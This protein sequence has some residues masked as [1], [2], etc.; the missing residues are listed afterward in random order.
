MKQAVFK[1]GLAAAAVAFAATSSFAQTKVTNQGISDSEIV[2]GFHGDMSG[3]VKVWGIPVLNGMKM[4]HLE[5]DGKDK[6]GPVDVELG[7]LAPSEHKLLV[8][9]YWGSKETQDKH[10]EAVQGIMHSLKPLND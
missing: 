2:V 6:D 4:A 1:A 7:L 5:W 10:D 3:P 8:V 9:T